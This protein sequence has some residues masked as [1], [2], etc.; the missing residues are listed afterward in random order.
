M[1]TLESRLDTDD[2]NELVARCVMVVLLLVLDIGLFL[3]STL[4]VCGG[5]DDFLCSLVAVGIL[6]ELVLALIGARRLFGGT[7]IA[8]GIANALLLLDSYL[9]G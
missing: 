6:S 3:T 8:A 9:R 1:E 5:N 2:L 4:H 7:Y